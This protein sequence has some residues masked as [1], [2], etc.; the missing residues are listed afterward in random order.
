MS[1]ADAALSRLFTLPDTR[2][3]I[4]VF[5]G[6]MRNTGDATLASCR[7]A[8]LV[9]AHWFGHLR[10]AAVA[11]VNALRQ[12]ATG[13]SA[14]CGTLEELLS[15]ED[16]DE[17]AR[18]Q[19]VALIESLK[20]PA[21]EQSQTWAALA[22]EMSDLQARLQVVIPQIVKLDQQY[23]FWNLD[24]YESQGPM[25]RAL[26]G[27]LS[28]TFLQLQGAWGSFS[29]DAA[30]VA[31][32][33]TQDV[34]QA[35]SLIA[36]LGLEEAQHAWTQ[37]GADAMQSLPMN[38]LLKSQSFA[39][40][41]GWFKLEVS[42]VGNLE[43]DMGLQPGPSN[44]VG[45]G[46]QAGAAVQMERLPSDQYG[47]FRLRLIGTG[48]YLTGTDANTL[49]QSAWADADSQKW[50]PL[51]AVLLQAL[52][53]GVVDGFYLI[54]RTTGLFAAAASAPASFP[55]SPQP[56]GGQLIGLVQQSG[57]PPMYGMRVFQIPNLPYEW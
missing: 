19:A 10:P 23:N 36:T 35:P 34:E 14:T 16:T 5:G 6:R 31:T 45:L 13:A 22:L 43:I 4:D 55:T 27:S 37:L 42:D 1:G 46:P 25:E 9:G 40:A 39:T 28:T 21:L 53:Q 52:G 48:L 50:R 57:M 12:Y 29:D 26:A 24:E 2:A 38:P 3:A 8:H 33:L 17:G 56:A 51:S 44:S 30:A 15:K 32:V 11:A 41:V 7:E 49:I 47:Y 18:Q 20:A 54:Q